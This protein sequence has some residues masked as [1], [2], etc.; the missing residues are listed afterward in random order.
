MDTIKKLK[1]AVYY[2]GAKFS[3]FPSFFNTINSSTN[4][5]NQK[6]IDVEL[7]KLTVLSENKKMR[8][9]NFNYTNEEQFIKQYHSIIE[10]FQKNFQIKDYPKLYLVDTFPDIFSNKTWDSMSIDKDDEKHFSI[11]R[12]IYYKKEYLTHGYFEFIIAHEIVHWIISE[13]SKEYFPYVP[14]IEEGLCDF[15]GT[16]IL[17]KYNIL[18]CEVIKNLIIYNRALKDDN[19][20]WK[21]YWKSY[22]ALSSVFHKNGLDYIID[23]IKKGR[24]EVSLLSYDNNSKCLIKNIKH[25]V[26]AKTI[27]NI[28]LEAGSIS[29]L[30]TKQYLLL[31]YIDTNYSQK[32]I[33][34]KL[35]TLDFL[36]NDILNILKEIESLGYIHSYKDNCFYNPNINLMQNIKYSL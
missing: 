4:P 5:I 33:D 11:P 36:E 20:L 32:I 26:Y 1:H 16:Y 18:E 3:C 29:I 21:Q 15:L 28:L 12:G 27:I 23:S 17:L 8:T 35:I 25:N 9:I 30:N 24:A 14:L 31:E 13:Y 2:Y 19:T 34:P 6:L 10:S 22:L 7:K